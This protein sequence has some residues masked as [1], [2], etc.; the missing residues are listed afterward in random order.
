[1]TFYPPAI[2]RNK[3]SKKISQQ[4]QHDNQKSIKIKVEKLDVG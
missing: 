4:D 2:L 3:I 1:M